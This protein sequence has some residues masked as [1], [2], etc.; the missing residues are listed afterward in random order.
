MATRQGSK[1]QPRREFIGNKAFPIQHKVRLALLM[2]TRP[3]FNRLLQKIPA[4]PDALVSSE[5]LESKFIDSSSLPFR[6]LQS[7][8]SKNMFLL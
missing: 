2:D 5:G 7:G 1:Y 8:K 4:K 6:D 3:T